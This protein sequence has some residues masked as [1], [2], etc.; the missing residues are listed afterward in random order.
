MCSFAIQSAQIAHSR[1][2]YVPPAT[3]SGRLLFIFNYNY[4]YNGSY[5]YQ[6]GC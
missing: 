4:S 3:A 1:V 6:A 2:Y 5:S